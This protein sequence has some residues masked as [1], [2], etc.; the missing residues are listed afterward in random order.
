MPQ[1]H[2]GSEGFEALASCCRRIPTVSKCVRQD[3]TTLTMQ[4]RAP[5]LARMMRTRAAIGALLASLSLAACRRDRALDL[6]ISDTTFVAALGELRRT[7]TDTTLD[8]TMKDSTRRMILRRHKVTSVQLEN[9]A[10]KL[11]DSPARASELW[12]KVES[13]A[14]VTPPPP[15]P[16]RPDSSGTPPMVN[17]PVPR[18]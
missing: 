7:E 12:R 1:R 14:R 13:P 3:G 4:Q 8:P 5:S 6:G 9:A 11:A 10:R 15:R 17:H 18:P 16:A 2:F